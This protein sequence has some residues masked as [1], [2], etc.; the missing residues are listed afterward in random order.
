M[1]YVRV[2]LCLIAL[3]VAGIA[4][5]RVWQLGSERRAVKSDLKELSHATYGL[6]NVDEW[7]VIVGTIIDRKIDEL[8]VTDQ[9]RP[10]LR[11]QLSELMLAM[12][13]EID[14]SLERANKKQGFKGGVRKAAFDLFVDLEAVKADVPRYADRLL[15]ELNKPSSRDRIRKLLHSEFYKMSANTTS[16][17]DYAARDAILQ[18]AGAHDVLELRTFLS[19]RLAH[20]ARSSRNALLVLLGSV[21]A[22]VLLVAFAGSRNIVELHMLTASACLLLLL[23]VL[24]PMMDIEASIGCFSLRL[25][26]QEICFQDQVLYYQSKSMLEVVMLMLR[27]EDPGLILI[28]VLVLLF[29]LLLPL[30][31]L[32]G[33]MGVL[34]TGHAPSSRFGTF[35]VYRSG[36]WSMADVLV[37]AMFMTYLGF[38][39][40]V[41]GQLSQLQRQDPRT[42]LLTTNGSELQTG[43]YIFLAY[44]IMGLVL[45]TLVQRRFKTPLHTAAPPVGA[46]A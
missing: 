36:K 33:T 6:F 16:L 26:G 4:G 14:G 5:H 40:I 30:A 1:R 45:S 10:E 43:F 35:L 3:A 37:V 27:D 29:S 19:A 2:A 34:I 13:E 39:G 24:L 20:L 23:G 18:R 28:G 21:A 22:L 12:I 17:A 8:E 31:K 11:A 9:N 44:C 32:V 7:M 25:I 38:S 42:E 41:N 15:D 46:T